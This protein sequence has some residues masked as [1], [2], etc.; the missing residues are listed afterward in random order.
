M[1]SQARVGKAE[2]IKI[3]KENREKH[4]SVVEEAW[5]GYLKESLR[6]LNE[7]IDRAK[8]GLRV[9]MSISLIMPIDHTADYDL[10]ISMLEMEVRNEIVLDEQEFA[11]LVLDNW[12]WKNQ[13]TTTNAMYASSLTR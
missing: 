13:W 2:L 1:P 9:N 12:G 4:R 7:Q 10:A 5:E 11:E 3:V 6:L 8:N